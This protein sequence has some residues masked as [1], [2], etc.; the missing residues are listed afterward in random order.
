MR[1][2]SIKDNPNLIKDLTNKAIINIDLTAPT[3]HLEKI[4]KVNKELQKE[5]DIDNLKH[6]VEEIKTSLSKILNLLQIKMR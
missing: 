4:A 6:D 2:V 1:Y 5:K 3:R